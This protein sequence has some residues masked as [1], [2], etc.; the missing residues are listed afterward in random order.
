MKKKKDKITLLINKDLGLHLDNIDDA[1]SKYSYEN[2]YMLDPELVEFIENQAKKETTRSLSCFTINIYMKKIPTKEEQSLF[3][4]TFHEHYK[5]YKEKEFK[6]NRNLL[7]LAWVLF[8]ISALVLVTYNIFSHASWMPQI[9]TYALDIIAY[10]F[11]WEFVDTFFFKRSI[12]TVDRR[13]YDIILNSKINF[14]LE[15]KK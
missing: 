10:V 7:I 4:K 3:V 11:M 5:G 13:F 8:G 15:K 9:V 2:H 1:Y 12:S 6:H 14:I